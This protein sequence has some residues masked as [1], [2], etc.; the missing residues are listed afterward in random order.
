MTELRR[1]AIPRGAAVL[2][3]LGDLERALHGGPAVQPVPDEPPSPG[4]PPD[5][6][7]EADDGAAGV[8]GTSGS[9]G[10][11]KR[12]ILSASSLVASASSTHQVLG[13]AGRWLL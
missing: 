4:L 3:V 5:A 6:P 10:T 8:S 11:A 12:S 7:A 1:L 13:G 9:T 2:S